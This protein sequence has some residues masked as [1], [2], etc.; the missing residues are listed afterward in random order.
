MEFFIRKNSTLPIIKVQIVK[1]GRVDFREF[2]NLTKDSTITFSMWNE[3]T[4]VYYIMNKPASVM[5]KPSTIDTEEVE[6][7]VYYQLTS[8][9]TRHIG[10][11][12]GEFKISNSQ[13]EIILPRRKKLFIN[14][15]DSISKPELCCKPYGG[16]SSGGGSSGGGIP[17]TPSNTP[18]P[19]TPSPSSITP[20]PT[21]TISQT[22]NYSLSCELNCEFTNSGDTPIGLFTFNSTGENLSEFTYNSETLKNIYDNNYE[23][24]EMAI[25]NWDGTM[26][27][28]RLEKTEYSNPE[29]TLSS[30]GENSIIESVSPILRT[31]RIKDGNKS[32]GSLGISETTV[33]CLYEKNSTTVLLTETTDKLYTAFKS[34]IEGPNFNC[35]STVNPKEREIN[36]FRESVMSQ[37][38]SGSQYYCVDMIYDLPFNSYNRIQQNGG[39]S[40]LYIE[41]M[42]LFLNAFYEPSFNGDFTFKVKGIVEWTTQTSEPW[43]VAGN[44]NEVQYRDTIGTYY[45]NNHNTLLPGID[46]NFIYQINRRSFNNTGLQG[47]SNFLGIYYPDIDNT[48]NNVAVAYNV[49]VD[50]PYVMSGVKGNLFDNFLHAHE[51]GHAVLGFHTWDYGTWTIPLGTFDGT[52]ISDCPNFPCNIPNSDCHTI[53]SYCANFG[54]TFINLEFRPER[55]AD[56]YSYASTYGQHMI[57]QD[58]PEEPY[59]ELS[60]ESNMSSPSFTFTVQFR[61]CVGGPWEIYGT[62]LTYND[63]PLYVLVSN[64]PSGSSECY[65]YK[66][67]SNEISMEC[68]GSNQ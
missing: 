65:E 16:G 9:E 48:I 2:D 3:E 38:L 36:Q 47:I 15:T 5:V 27:I 6:Y 22:P 29:I 20:T 19:P 32:I 46:Y 4:N 43:N 41:S 61:D 60:I 50:L 30:Q 40:Q 57:C 35:G 68:Y 37:S 14:I 34:F 31:Y 56:G 49:N 59:C 51:V 28:M 10:G 12:I 62:G 23:S 52:Y 8:H 7:Y 11:Y 54:I 17:P 39:N 44:P 21:P 18:I 53:M 13:G 24:F 66:I 33:Y 26:A 63:F 55:I 67:T 42:N 45:K 1:D 58:T 25:P 64:L